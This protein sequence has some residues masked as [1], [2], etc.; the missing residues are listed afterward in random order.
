MKEARLKLIAVITHYFLD[1]PLIIGGV[2]L[3]IETQI[4]APTPRLLSNI[5]RVRLVIPP[6]WGGAAVISFFMLIGEIML[7]KCGSD[8]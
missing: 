6:P 5:T 4:T 3:F 8:R 2:L 1:L 7:D